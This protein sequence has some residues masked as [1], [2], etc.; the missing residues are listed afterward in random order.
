MFYA[1]VTIYNTDQFNQKFCFYCFA[2]VTQ[3][4]EGS[5][6]DSGP[7]RQSKQV[8][9]D[10]ICYFVPYTCMSMYTVFTADCPFSTQTAA[11]IRPLS[12][13]SMHNE[14][15]MHFVCIYMHV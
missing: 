12:A 10:H 5:G 1:T 11:K 6:G 2:G 7:T 4:F 14:R 9:H 15:V 13:K 8:Y 3:I